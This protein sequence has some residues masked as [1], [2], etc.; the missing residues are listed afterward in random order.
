MEY[1]IPHYYREFHCI[2][3]KCP[4]TCCAGWEI[5]ID[6]RTLQGYRNYP[7][8]FGKRLQHFIDW[9]QGVF[10]QHGTRCAFLDEHNLCDIYANAGREMLCRTCRRYPRHYEEFENL[11]EISLSVSCPQVAHMLLAMS[12]KVT[13]VT[14]SQDV[15]EESYEEF[16]FFLFTKLQDIRE[17][18]FEIAQNRTYSLYLR[19]MLILALVH[20]FQV[21]IQKERLY[22]VDERIAWYRK[23]CTDNSEDSLYRK[24]LMQ[25]R[26]ERRTDDHIVKQ[27]TFRYPGKSRKQQKNQM[28]QMLYRLEVLDSKWKKDLKVWDKILTTIPETN[29]LY[30][31]QNPEW[32]IQGE[33]LLVYFLYTYFCGAVY[34]EEAFAKAKAAVVH[35][36][37]LECLFAAETFHNGR[38]DR[39]GQE[40]CLYRYA[41][42]VEHSERNLRRIEEY[43]NHD[44]NFNMKNLICYLLD[45]YEEI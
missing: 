9:K 13:F 8:K 41:R 7:G 18:M 23:L 40:R 32:E 20:D 38:Y 1:T 44:H 37:L 27:K 43:M 14:Y 45:S 21:R 36:L 3:D 6:G 11:R 24:I 30:R 12:Q 17:L 10:R 2:A 39:A 42:E 35:V 28:I 19:M 29:D 4:S 34:D 33:Q 31:H 22:E 25:C 15:G 16:D 26:E 5:V